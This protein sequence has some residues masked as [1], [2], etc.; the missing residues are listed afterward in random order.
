MAQSLSQV[1]VHIVYS[2][3]NRVAWLDDAEMRTQLD[4][5]NATILKGNVDSP[6]L[7]LNGGEDRTGTHK[8]CQEPLKVCLTTFKKVPDTFFT[9]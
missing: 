6:V 2:T 8:R 3:K 1:I 9:G 7:L 4:A 5:Y